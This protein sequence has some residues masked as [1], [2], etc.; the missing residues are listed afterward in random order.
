MKSSELCIYDWD[1]WTWYTNLTF[2]FKFSHTDWEK[3]NSQYLSEKIY[4]LRL[5]LF[6]W[7][8]FYSSRIL[9]YEISKGGRLFEFGSKQILWSKFCHVLT[10][11]CIL[12]MYRVESLQSCPALCGPMDCSPPGSSVHGII[13]A[14][15]L[16]W[17][18]IPFPRDLPNSGIEP[19]SPALAGR[20]FTTD[21]PEAPV[22]IYH[23]LNGIFTSFTLNFFSL[24]RVWLMT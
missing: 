16:E 8:D 12:Y 13:Q 6:R 21:P 9:C 2:A 14:R 1:K 17:V 7:T 19:A 20:L 4:W 18:A 22:T 24:Y 3:Q 10:E 15:M 11:I 5:F 23:M